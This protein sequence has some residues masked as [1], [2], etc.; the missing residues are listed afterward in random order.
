MTETNATAPRA[1]GL[2][3]TVVIKIGSSSVMRERG[4]SDHSVS[5]E[6]AAALPEGA[7]ELALS[8]LALVVDTLVTLRRS[9]YRALLVTSGAV[10]VGCRELGLVRRPGMPSGA[11]ADEHAAA[12]A[13]IQA[14]A[15]VGQSV[16]M[17]TYSDLLKL[18]GQPAAQVLLTS[19]DLGSEYQYENARNTLNALL[20]MGVIPI[21]NENDTVATEE[22]KY[23]DNDWMSALVSTAVAADWLFLLTDV[24]QLCT[25]NPRTDP[26]AKPISKVLDVESL[27]VGTTSSGKTGT[28]WGTGGMTTKITAARLATA[29]GVRVCLLHG[30]YPER[31]LDFVFDRPG[32]LG[33]V[34]EPRKKPLAGHR[35]R[36]ISHCLPP[37]GTI[38]LHEFALAKLLSTSSTADVLTTDIDRAEGVWMKNSAVKICN[39][40][41]DEI[42][43]GICSYGS[44][45]LH[46]FKGLDGSKIT[47][48]LG[49]PA[50]AVVVYE[51]DMAVIANSHSDTLVLPEDP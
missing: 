27:D 34:F 30:R 13:K 21:V 36:W 17:R 8:T 49:T 14:C 10:G 15:A 29:A 3:G 19:Q 35:K 5:S 12:M 39:S 47:K 7:G 6:A 32:Q 20:D 33:T 41:G 37:R 38:T 1:S 25:A 2:A 9:G 4:G 51:Y 40:H 48:L 50:N 44:G 24:D 23:G 42:A 18:A 28:Q 11:T 16:L 43:R 31:V 45:E 46:D 22:L 26:T